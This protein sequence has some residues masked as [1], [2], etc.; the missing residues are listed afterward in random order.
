M[1]MNGR[2]CFRDSVRGASEAGSGGI[3]G[4]L[5]DSATLRSRR[6]EKLQRRLQDIG[7]NAQVLYK[8]SDGIKNKRDPCISSNTRTGARS[9]RFL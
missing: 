2:Q 8:A 1:W 7:M 5:E 9:R 3:A 6:I 4:S